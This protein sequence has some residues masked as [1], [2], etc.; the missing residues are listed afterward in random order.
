MQKQH[1]YL[2]T[3][4]RRCWIIALFWLR[5]LE[6]AVLKTWRV[7]F[8]DVVIPIP[9]LLS[10]SISNYRLFLCFIHSIYYALHITYIYKSIYVY[11]TYITCGFVWTCGL[12]GDGLVVMYGLVQ[13]FWCDIYVLCECYMWYC[14]IYIYI[15]MCVCVCV[16]LSMWKSKKL[17]LK[18]KSDLFAEKGRRQSD[19]FA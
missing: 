12:V 11:I 18:L 14:H 13:L 2:Q 19:L 6:V 5:S 3:V 16:C 17:K 10:L 7:I 8:G 15:Y 9:V 1:C 4:I